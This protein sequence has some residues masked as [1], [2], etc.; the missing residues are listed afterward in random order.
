MKRIIPIVVVL[1][2]LGLIGWRL[3]SNKQHI[4]EKKKPVAS[5]NVVIPVNVIKV[6]KADVNDQLI[7]TGTLVPSL[8]S[9]IMATAGGKLVAV[10]FELGSY[11]SKGATIAQIDNKMLQLKTE[12]SELAKS[13]YESDYKRNKTL[14]EGDATTE[15]NVQDIKYNYD[16]TVNQISQLQQQIAD[17]NIKAPISGQIVVKKLEAGTYVSAGAVLGSIVDISTLKVDVMITEKDA[18]T[19]K[20]GQPVTVT[21]EV[22]PSEKFKGTISFI[23]QKGDATHNY[24]IQVKLPNTSAHP[25]KAGTY[26]YVDFARK[27]NAPLLL[28]PRTALVESFKNPYVYV[29]EN[30]KAV[31]RKIIPGREI[32]NNVEVVEGIN[33]GEEVVVNGQINLSEGASVK[34]ID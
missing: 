21:T 7:K 26:V 30:G 27:S 6:A 18:Y 13:K 12:A 20:V 28:I 24:Q 17:N 34:M 15:Q 22:Y 23:S 31:V 4:D 32:G 5:G 33:V 1:G 29:V 8:E 3:A 10:N 11:V 19:L 16:N 9:D 2:V 14:L 25:L